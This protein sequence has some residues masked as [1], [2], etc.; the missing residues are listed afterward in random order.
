ME[1]IQREIL[2]RGPVTT[3]YYMYPDFQYI[4]GQEGM[5]GQFYKGGNPLGSKKNSLI[6]MWNG[7]GENL[8]G[9]AIT[10][11][12]WGTYSYKNENDNKTI[13]IPYWICLN[14]WGVGWGQSGFSSYED[15]TGLPEDLDGG[16]YFWMVRGLNNCDIGANV[17]AGQPDIK[18]ISFPGV[19][20]KYG[21]GLP[22]PTHG[23]GSAINFISPITN[24]EIYT[25]NDNRF[26]FNMAEPAGG[27]YT[28][29]E[30]VDENNNLI[31]EFQIKSM[32]PPSP[33]TLFWEEIR[34]TF[35]LGKITEKMSDNDID[36]VIKVDKSIVEKLKKITKLQDNPLLIVDGEQM[37]FLKVVSENSIKVYRAT[38]NS[39]LEVH[40]PGSNLE[41]MPYKE[42]GVNDLSKYANQC[43]FDTEVIEE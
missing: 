21:W 12:G 34:P 2:E 24:D 13:K 31:T 6:Y 38:N 33:Y 9:H 7:E 36:S 19:K 41:I 10:I 15:R 29:R 20:D 35:C 43:V 17:T 30:I 37:Q 1:A 14:S 42:L 32:T 25:G 8:G 11:V 27:T 28:E 16:G 5:G 40:A 4:F 3:G 23:K 26:Q 18:N 39:L 22:P